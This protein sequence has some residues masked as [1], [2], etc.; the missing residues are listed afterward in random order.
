M[1]QRLTG[2]NSA[3]HFHVCVHTEPVNMTL[4][5]NEALA[6]VQLS[7]IQSYWVQAGTDMA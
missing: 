6:L 3:P 2:L 7:L 4:P 1:L 5:G